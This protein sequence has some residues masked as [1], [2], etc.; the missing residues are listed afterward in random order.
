MTHLTYKISQFLLIVAA[1]NRSGRLRRR[2]LRH[3]ACDA[4]RTADR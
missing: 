1:L 4:R 3:H 2:F